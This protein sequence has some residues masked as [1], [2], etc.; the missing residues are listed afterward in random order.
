MR[1]ER[2]LLSPLKII[3]AETRAERSRTRA[4][5][6][7][8]PALGLQGPCKRGTERERERERDL[9]GHGL[10]M[11]TACVGGR[12]SESC[13]HPWSG[14]VLKAVELMDENARGAERVA[15]PLH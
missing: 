4:W 9:G 15:G 2:P 8:P 5:S 14:G 3:D 13:A 6:H 7:E 10:Q 1:S 12:R 11:C